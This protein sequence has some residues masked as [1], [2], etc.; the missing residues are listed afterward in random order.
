M[1]AVVI[2]P[3]TFVGMSNFLGGAVL[4]CLRRILVGFPLQNEGSDPNRLNRGENYCRNQT[5]D[6]CR[7]Q[8]LSYH[9]RLMTGESCAVPGVVSSV[10]YRRDWRESHEVNE[11]QPE[12]QRKRANDSAVLRQGCGA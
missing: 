1:T 7:Q 2:R 4:N 11:P 3:R 6:N 10:M 9:E 5:G 12:Y 8:G